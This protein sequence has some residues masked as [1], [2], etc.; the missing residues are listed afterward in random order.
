[1]KKHHKHLPSP[2]ETAPSSSFFNIDWDTISHWISEHL[3]EGIIG[4]AA[5]FF[6]LA[7]LYYSMFGHLQ[8]IEADYFKAATAFQ[9]FS[10]STENAET[11]QAAL[12]TLDTLLAQR[13]ELH[14]AYDGLIAQILIN[15]GRIQEAE[16][17]ARAALLRTQKNDLSHYTDFAQT[18]LLIGEKKF[19]EALV[20]TE[21]LT[22]KMTES[23]QNHT[24]AK[25]SFGETLLAFN[26]LRLAML[27]QKTGAT[28]KEL[29]TWETW[30]SFHQNYPAT[31]EKVVRQFEM[32]KISLADY[33]ANRQKILK[34]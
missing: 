10:S 17:F 23:S 7:L 16:P 18:T 20:K 14:A 34:K 5:L 9:T 11:R 30:E 3:K 21:A 8:N 26:L 13:P 29:K 22:Q 27:D 31:Y 1:M 12:N 2:F 24:L 28:Q 33:V 32:H 6:L 19:A 15:E 25:Q 4:V